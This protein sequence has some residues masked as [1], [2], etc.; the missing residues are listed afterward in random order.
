M[1]TRSRHAAKRDRWLKD[2][3][4]SLEGGG[5][6]D[7]IGL[8]EARLTLK[9]EVDVEV[10]GPAA[11]I[12]VVAEEARRGS[13]SV[14]VGLLPANF[15]ADRPDVHGQETQPSDHDRRDLG[16]IGDE[17]SRKIVSSEKSTNSPVS[18]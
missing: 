11:E 4:W 16:A 5:S 7:C 10:G 1:A 9:P 13:A 18:L 6:R 8:A 2:S 3:R 15:A 12:D 14:G 17:L